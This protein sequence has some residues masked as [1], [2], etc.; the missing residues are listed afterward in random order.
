MST[1]TNETSLGLGG[2]CPEGRYCPAQ[3][4]DPILC[5]N[6][7]FRNTTMGESSSDC[8]ACLPGMYCGTEGLSQPTGPCQAGFYCLSGNNVANPSGIITHNH[9]QSLTL[10]M[11]SNFPCFL[12]VC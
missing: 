4:E 5:P 11:L 8:Y 7:T 12:V 2:P 6:S 1:P 9:C 10:C 3:T